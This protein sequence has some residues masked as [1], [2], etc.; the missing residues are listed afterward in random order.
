MKKIRPFYFLA[1]YRIYSFASDRSQEVLELCRRE[2]ISFLDGY[3]CDERFC[4]VIPLV[5]SFRFE[6]AARELEPKLLAS[7]GIP[8]IILR[9]R[10]R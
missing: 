8:S 6:R 9:Y 10:H 1:G 5:P 3:F 4:V 7:R 2:G